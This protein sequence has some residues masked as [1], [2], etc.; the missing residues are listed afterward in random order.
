[1]EGDNTQLY[2]EGSGGYCVAN[3]NLVSHKIYFTKQALLAQLEP[4]IFAAIKLNM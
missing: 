4:R 3:T 1:M 2:I